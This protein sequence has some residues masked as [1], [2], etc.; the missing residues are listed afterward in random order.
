MSLVVY[1]Q[2]SSFSDPFGLF[3]KMIRH[4]A[5]FLVIKLLACKKA[6]IVNDDMQAIRIRL[7]D[8]DKEFFHHG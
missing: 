4:I 2:W 6:A 5:L 7:D 8:P 1:V 3:R